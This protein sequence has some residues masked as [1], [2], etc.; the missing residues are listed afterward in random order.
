MVG[1]LVSIFTA[2]FIT[3]LLLKSFIS[4]FH[5]TKT[6]YFGVKVG[7]EKESKIFDFIGKKI[8]FSLS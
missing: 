7:E 8:F 3:K 4:A 6:E 1:I 2:V 5:I